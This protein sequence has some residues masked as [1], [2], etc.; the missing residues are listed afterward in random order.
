MAKY[1]INK[2]KWHWT[3]EQIRIVKQFLEVQYQPLSPTV[4]FFLSPSP[5]CVVVRYVQ[6]IQY[7]PVSD[8]ELGIWLVPKKWYPV[9][10]GIL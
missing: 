2:M 1:Y 9:L 10:S 5:F 6:D 7:Y 4:Y 8:Q 3:E